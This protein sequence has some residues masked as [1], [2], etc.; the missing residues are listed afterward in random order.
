MGY[1]DATNLPVRRLAQEYVLADNFFH[2]AFDG[3]SPLD[4]WLTFSRCHPLPM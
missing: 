2:A 4:R 1:Y 3:S